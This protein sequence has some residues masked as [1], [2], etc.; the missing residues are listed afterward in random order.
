M[1][2]LCQYINKKFIY[3]VDP[4]FIHGLL[5]E[6]TSYVTPVNYIILYAVL[7]SWPR[8]AC[9]MNIRREKCLLSLRF[10]FDKII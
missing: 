7:L 2:H 3:G 9:F 8:G 4:S 1:V 5:G 6:K 10:D